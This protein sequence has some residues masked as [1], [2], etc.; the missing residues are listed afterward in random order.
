MSIDSVHMPSSMYKATVEKVKHYFKKIKPGNPSIPILTLC[1]STFN[2]GE[3]GVCCLCVKNVL[4]AN[5]NRASL[6][7]LK[8]DI[9]SR[10]LQVLSM[11]NCGREKKSAQ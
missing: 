1:K 9:E 4:E 11:Y 7:F 6:N 10:T 2:E 8:S 3:S 5:V